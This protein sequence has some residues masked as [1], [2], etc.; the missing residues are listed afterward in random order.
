M[1][2]GVNVLT[3]TA[4]V[5]STDTIRIAVHDGDRDDET[6]LG[7]YLTEGHPIPSLF[8]GDNAVHVPANISFQGTIIRI[9]PTTNIVKDQTFTFDII[10]RNGSGSATKPINLEIIPLFD[11]NED[12][13]FSVSDYDEIRKLVDTYLTIQDMPDEIIASDSV[14]YTHLT[15][16]TKRIV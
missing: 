13:E 6:D 15:L 3:E 12:I 9:T 14:S 11:D 16:P 4:P 5:W 1:S 10:A 2:L 7:I 8:L